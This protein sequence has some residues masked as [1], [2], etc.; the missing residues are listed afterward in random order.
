LGKLPVQICQR[1]LEQM[2]VA[3]VLGSFELLENMLAGQQQALLVALSG[4]LSGSQW[5]LGWRRS[6]DCLSLLLL[7]RLTLPTSCHEE[8]IPTQ[9][10]AKGGFVQILDSLSG[11]NQEKYYGA[12][13]AKT[14]K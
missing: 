10:T 9:V 8:I 7:D 6:G 4:E 14:P 1:R 12:F 2:A 5:R 13:Q 3:R 11:E